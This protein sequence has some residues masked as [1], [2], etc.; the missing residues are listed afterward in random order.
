MTLTLE[1]Q[2]AI[3]EHGYAMYTVDGDLLVAAAIINDLEHGTPLDDLWKRMKR[4][5]AA[6]LEGET[7]WCHEVID[8]AVEE[9]IYLALKKFLP[10]H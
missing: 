3:K 7:Y 2:R 10:Q 9:A 1:T 4:I 6:V 5:Q 8:T